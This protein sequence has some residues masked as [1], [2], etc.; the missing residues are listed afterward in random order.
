VSDPTY[1]YID[2]HAWNAMWETLNEKGV[3]RHNEEAADLG[4][5][6]LVLPGYPFIFAVDVNL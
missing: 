2:Q 6:N 1:V 4:I 5:Q 3:V